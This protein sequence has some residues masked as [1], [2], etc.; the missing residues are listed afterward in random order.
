M[1]GLTGT[2]LQDGTFD[3]LS[4]KWTQHWST[5]RWTDR[6]NDKRMNKRAARGAE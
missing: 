4:R 5:E 1:K 2:Y 3:M 6:L